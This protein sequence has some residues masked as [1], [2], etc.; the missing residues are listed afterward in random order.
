MVPEQSV[1]HEPEDVPIPEADDLVIEIFTEKMIAFDES[2]TDVLEI[3]AVTGADKRRV[4]V[5]EKKMTDE[6]KKLF[7]RAKEAELQ[8]WL[9]HK[10]FDVVNKKI[11][12]KRGVMRARWGLTWTSTSKNKARL[13]LGVP[14]PR[15]DRSPSRQ[16]PTFCTGLDV[17][18]RGVIQ[19]KACVGRHQHGILVRR[20]GA[21]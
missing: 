10:V 13:R 5:N 11:A 16:P 2:S 17:P 8:S 19:L 1:L 7:R 20:G 4:E 21:L 14:R 12:D 18:V 6:D 3:F 9:D 15:P